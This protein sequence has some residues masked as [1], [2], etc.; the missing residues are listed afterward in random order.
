MLCQTGPMRRVVPVAIVTLGLLLGSVTPALAAPSPGAQPVPGQPVC[1]IQ[2]DRLVRLTGLAATDTGYAVVNNS[3][4]GNVAMR[5]SF[6]NQQCRYQ[7]SVGYP[8]GAR[9]PQ[10]LAVAPDGTLWIADTGDNPTGANHRTTIAVWKLAPGTNGEP[11]RYR[12]AYPDGA[13]D[14]EALL[15]TGAGI[16]VV[17]T[18]ETGGVAGLYIP[19]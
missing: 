3:P 18:K 6:V 16:P 1:S 19:T 14:A 5:V 10:D 11:V 17:V 13:H 2:D 7:R 9:D 12:L 4:D 8:V 15:L